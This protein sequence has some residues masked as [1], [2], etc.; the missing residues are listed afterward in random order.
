MERRKPLAVEPG[1]SNSTINAPPPTS[2]RLDKYRQK[3]DGAKFRMLNE[4][5]YSGEGINQ[6]E[7]DSYHQGFASQVK[8]WPTNPV[9]VISKQISKL[10]QKRGLA[11][12]DMGCGEAQ[13]AREWSSKHV[14]HSFDLVAHDPKLVTCCDISRRVPLG[15]ESLDVAVYSLSLMGIDVTS[16][17]LEAF[18]VL[19]PGGLM[20]LA[21][22]KSRFVAAEDQDLEPEHGMRKGIKRFQNQLIHMGFEL[23][24]SDL[25]SNTMFVLMKFRKSNEV[26]EPGLNVQVLLGNCPYKRR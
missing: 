3:L 18:R 9:S 22:V 15:D 12:A 21:E 10:P 23:I 14:I 7:F 13:L 2:S 1:E 4:S 26:A 20:I 5:L 24:M 16:F 6:A 8:S 11:I 17:F 19:K 25:K